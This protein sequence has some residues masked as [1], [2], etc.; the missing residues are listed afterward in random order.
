M[1]GPALHGG[2][3][4]YGGT[5][6]T[7]SG[8]CRPAIRLAAMMEVHTIFIMTHDSSASA[9]TGRRTS[10]SSTSRRCVRSRTWRRVE[11]QVR[12]GW[13]RY[14]GRKGDLV[15]VNTFGM[16]GRIA[17]VREHFGITARAVAEAGRG[18]PGLSGPFPPATAWSS[19]GATS[20]GPRRGGA[21]TASTA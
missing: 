13:D 19:R 9:R 2:L 1:N 14:A 7:F 21:L 11:A 6:M 16:S 17:A 10:R 20:T 15:G 8:D 3:I 5:F 12:L 18:R 4:P